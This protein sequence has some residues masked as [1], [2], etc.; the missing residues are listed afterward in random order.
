MKIHANRVPDEGCQ[1]RAAYD[2]AQ[3]D[4]DREDVHPDRPF[5]VEVTI[6]K[7]Q[8]ELI[9]RAG[10]RCALRC[11][12]ARCLEDFS[13]T[14]GPDAIFSYHVRPGDVVDITEDVRQ[15]VVLAYPVIPVCR[16]ECRGLCPVCGQN[17]NRGSCAHQAS[18]SESSR[19]AGA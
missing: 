3:L 5:E 13:M 2:P 14:V 4:M 8:E 6:H 1:Q 11:T 9:V 7:S 16:P 17:L 19:E 10:I 15:E 18:P 12:C